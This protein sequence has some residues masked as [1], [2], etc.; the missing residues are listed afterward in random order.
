MGKFG[1][2]DRNAE[3]QM[4]LDFAKRMEMAVENS[5]FQKRQEHRVMYK[6]GGRR[7]QVDYILCRRCNLKEISDC[8][9]L[10][11]ESVARQHRMVVCKMT[12]VMRRMK[13][14]KWWRRDW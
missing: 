1:L 2:Q 7:T 10:V 14:T 6:S 5:F 12:L 11:G 4:V 13:R 9:V 3:E 8:K